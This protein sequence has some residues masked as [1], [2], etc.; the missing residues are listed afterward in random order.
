[1]KTGMKPVRSLAHAMLASVFVSGGIHTLLHPEHAAKQAE[2]VSQ[3]LAAATENTAPWLPTGP[4]AVVRAN[5]AIQV[6]GAALLASGRLPR[7]AALALAASL[8]PTTLVG[9]AWWRYQDPAQRSNHRN[10][11][12]KNVAILGG[13]ALTA[14]DTQGRPGLGWRA[15][16]ATE[17]AAKRVGRLRRR[18]VERVTP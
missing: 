1:M 11:F 12:L 18:A 13:L 10:H 2:P 3:R 14:V 15:S 9:H 4:V 8:V 7:L 5:A 17:V 6:G 16:H